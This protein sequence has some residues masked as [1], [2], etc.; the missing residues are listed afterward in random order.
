[1]QNQGMQQPYKGQLRM[2]F[3]LGGM[4]R[5]AFMKLM[6]GITGTGIAAGSGLLKFGKAAK[7]VPKVTETI[8]QSNA[9]GMPP[10]FP[11]VS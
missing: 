2:P 10:W 6:G 8:V 7:V 9:A 1:M 5:R 3:G 4:S 11:I